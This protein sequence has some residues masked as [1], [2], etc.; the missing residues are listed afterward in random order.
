MMLLD[1][2]D[3]SSNE[4][5]IATQ[6]HAKLLDR[7]AVFVLAN[8]GRQDGQPAFVSAGV[9]KCFLGCQPATSPSLMEKVPL[10]IAESQKWPS[11]QHQRHLPVFFLSLSLQ[12]ISCVFI[13][14]TIHIKHALWKIHSKLTVICCTLEFYH[15]EGSV[16]RSW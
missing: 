16:L 13:M 1:I 4:D 5:H 14:Q 12:F 3:L 8:E 15:S 6:P 7:P 10:D 2:I 11:P 9:W